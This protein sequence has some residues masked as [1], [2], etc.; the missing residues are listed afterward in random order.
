MFLALMLIAHY[1]GCK[2]WQG[3]A[4]CLPNTRGSSPVESNITPLR[5]YIENSCTYDLGNLTL[6]QIKAY[7]VKELVPYSN[8]WSYH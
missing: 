8:Y 1:T 2:V 5:V 4:Q 6:S 7:Q 3:T